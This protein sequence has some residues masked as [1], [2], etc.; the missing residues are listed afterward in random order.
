MVCVCACVCVCV[1][2]CMCMYACVCVF[3][4]FHTGRCVR[5]KSSVYGKTNGCY[6]LVRSCTLT[7]THTLSLTSFAKKG[8]LWHRACFVCHDCSGSLYDTGGFFEAKGKVFCEKHFKVRPPTAH[9]HPHPPHTHAHTCTHMH[10]RVVG[11][12]GAEMPCVFNCYPGSH[13]QCT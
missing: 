11:E 2:V 8:Q 13:S 6:A 3:I 12:G 10:T 4:A 1:C 9:T 5:C 7:H